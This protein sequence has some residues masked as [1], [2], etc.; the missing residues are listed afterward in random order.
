MRLMMPDGDLCNYGSCLRCEHLKKDA[1]ERCITL[2]AIYERRKEDFL[3]QRS[4]KHEEESEEKTKSAPERLKEK[5]YQAIPIRESLKDEGKYS[6]PLIMIQMEVNR[7]TG[8]I[9]NKFLTV[10]DQKHQDEGET[11]K[12]K[13]ERDTLPII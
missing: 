6:T 1:D 9:I 4:V 2:R 12:T 11:P 8:Q 10:Y 3:S 13:G 5:C 7:S